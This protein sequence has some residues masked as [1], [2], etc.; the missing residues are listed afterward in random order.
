VLAAKAASM[1][2]IAVPEKGE[3][4]QPAFGLADLVVDSLLDVDASALD[5]LEA[6]R[7]VREP[8]GTTPPASDAPW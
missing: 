4:H 2:C 7:V 1:A 5:A 6:L 3:G 8:P